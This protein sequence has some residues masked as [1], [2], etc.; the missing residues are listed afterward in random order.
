M[1]AQS[2][3]LCLMLPEFWK[4]VSIW[5]DMKARLDMIKPDEFLLIGFS[6]SCNKF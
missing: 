1:H 4:T 3:S 5:T 2:L 6:V